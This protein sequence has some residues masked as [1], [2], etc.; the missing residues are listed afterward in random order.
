MPKSSFHWALQLLT[1]ETN[2]KMASLKTHMPH[3]G[4]ANMRE[5][6]QG[7]IPGVELRA[8]QDWAATGSGGKGL[9]GRKTQIKPEGNNRTSGQHS[10]G[11]KALCFSQ[12]GWKAASLSIAG[13]KIIRWHPAW[14]TGYPNGKKKHIGFSRSASLNPLL[15][16][17]GSLV[18]AHLHF[19]HRGR[20]CTAVPIDTEALQEAPNQQ[21]I[22]KSLGGESKSHT[23][24]KHHLQEKL[25]CHGA[26]T[27]QKSII[28]LV[29]STSA[30]LQHAALCNCFAE[31]HRQMCH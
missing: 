30:V 3:S 10:D 25:G 15:L 22:G 23:E 8:A 16:P 18:D 24:Q 14:K 11:L 4:E 20:P 26:Q 2:K 7:T 17:A 29:K 21:H 5:R 27:P 13:D 12:G 31:R 19:H 28:L 9:A 1:N 6:T